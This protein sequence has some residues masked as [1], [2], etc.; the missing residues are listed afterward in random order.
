METPTDH[1]IHIRREAEQLF[2][3][4]CPGHHAAQGSIALAWKVLHEL[5]NNSSGLDI[6]DLNTLS[7]IIHK[8]V[9]AFTQL[10]SVELKI[11]D[12][13]IKRAEFEMR[14]KQLE[15]ALKSAAQPGGLTPEI[16][17]EIERRLNLL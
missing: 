12:S 3:A 10:K 5:L 4:A 1:L 11:H 9:T 14:K 13:E 8:L 6:R 7:A 15:D 2:E 16:L 17:R